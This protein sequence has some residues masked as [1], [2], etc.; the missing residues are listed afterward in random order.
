MKSPNKLGRAKQHSC[1]GLIMLGHLASNRHVA[2]MTQFVQSWGIIKKLFLHDPALIKAYLFITNLN[3]FFI[4]AHDG[5]CVGSVT[6][7]T[8]R[9]IFDHVSPPASEKR[10]CYSKSLFQDNFS[11]RHPAELLPIRSSKSWYAIITC[12]C[13]RLRD[14]STLRKFLRSPLQSKAA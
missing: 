6:A 2:C 7:I 10:F 3:R 13:G 9:D 14:G 11:G 1:R 5:Y 12:F 8:A 4:P